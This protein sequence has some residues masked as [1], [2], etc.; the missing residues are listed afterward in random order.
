MD[1]QP[2]GQVK[3][4]SAPEEPAESSAAAPLPPTIELGAPPPGIA[5]PAAGSEPGERNYPPPPVPEHALR[6]SAQLQPIQLQQDA[7]VGRSVGGFVIEQPLGEGGMGLVYLARHPILNRRFAVKVL[8]P[9]A[10]QNAWVARSFMREAQTLSALKHPHV[11]DI[12]DFGQLDDER[13]YMVMEYLEGKTLAHELAEQGR[14]PCVTAL[15]MADQILDALAAAHSVDVIHRDLKPANVILAR[16]SGGREVVKLLDFGLSKIAPTALAGEVQEG[17]SALAGTPEYVAPEQARGQPACKQSDLYSFGVMLFEMLTGQLPFALAEGRTD[18]TVWLL[19][20]HAN[21]PAPKITPLPNGSPFPADLEI[22]VAALLAKQ[23]QDRPQTAADARTQVQKILQ[24]LARD[25]AMALAPPTVQTP[26]VQPPPKVD[27]ISM[28][29]AV[30]P[31][32]SAPWIIG[33]AVA[34]VIALTAFLLSGSS[35]NQPRIAPGET[36][37]TVRTAQPPPTPAPAPAKTEDAVVPLQ[38]D[39]K[40]VAKVEPL[41]EPAPKPAEP[42]PVAAKVEPRKKPLRAPVEECDPS[43]KWRASAQGRLQEVQQLAAGAG[44]ARSWSLFEKAEPSLIDAIAKAETPAQ[45]GEVEQRIRS[46]ARS[47]KPGGK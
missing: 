31:R 37:V 6:P 35:E 8:R 39:P 41:P 5:A 4:P 11:V 36:V 13:Q 27:T 32:N 28:E 7:L 33:G 43:P 42:A 19:N 47:V 12:V 45:C 40:L 29:L 25:E 46:L 30:P 3:N 24:T 23:P 1:T 20:M 34:G 18:R 9:E 22:L 21:M 38:P 10:A 17:R 2:M 15:Q 26:K 14:L 16:I 44:N